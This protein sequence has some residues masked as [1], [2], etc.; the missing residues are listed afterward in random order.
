MY[1]NKKICKLAITIIAAS[2]L[3]IASTSYFINAAKAQLPQAIC[4]NGPILQSTNRNIMPV[5]LVHGYNEGP[6]VWSTW[7]GLLRTD[8]IPFCTLSFSQF[9]E[10]FDQCGSAS[11]HSKELGSLIKFVENKAGTNQVN[12]VAHSKGGLDSR[13]YLEDTRI[14]DVD[15]LIMIGTPNAG[16]PI[17]DLNLLDQCVP[18]ADDLKTVA[19]DTKA[20]ENTHTH[21]YTIIGKWTPP[22]PFAIPV[23]V[24]A[25]P[26]LSWNLADPSF[27]PASIPSNCPQVLLG[28]E[29]R[30]YSYL[31]T[32]GFAS[33]D[34]IVPQESALSLPYSKNIGS[35]ND[36]HTNLLS[37]KSFVKAEPYLLGVKQ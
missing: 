26:L 20:Q 21:Y 13:V 24:W 7:E 18:A 30:G 15:K 4:T 28:F 5:V 17:E 11:D 10:Q 8:G 22:L 6:D 34:G 29:I 19:T 33:N 14:K 31:T 9:S 12:I 32:R 23:Y 1:T 3:I 16:D 35:T 37:T 27:L 25:N 2:L 36:C